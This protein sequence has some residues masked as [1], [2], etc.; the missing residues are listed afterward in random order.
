MDNRHNFAGKG[1][2][3]CISLDNLVVYLHNPSTYPR[4]CKSHGPGSKIIPLINITDIICFAHDA[5]YTDEV[6]VNYQ[7]N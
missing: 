7:N 4:I 2:L 3:I 5:E 1:Q 6:Y